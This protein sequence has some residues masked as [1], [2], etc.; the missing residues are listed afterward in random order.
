MFIDS[1]QFLNSSLSKLVENLIIPGEERKKFDILHQ[2]FDETS[3][4]LL[5]RKGVYP[6][7]YMDSWNRFSEVKL[8][9]K[10]SFY[11]TLREE[12]ISEE[13][14]KHAKV[15]FTHFKMG[16]L[17]EYHD[18][19]L[20]AD[21]LQLA[22]VF[23][24]FRTLSMTKYGLDPVYYMSAPGLSWDAALRMTG[25]ELEQIMDITI[26]E[27]LELGIRGGISMITHRRAEARNKYMKN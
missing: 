7:D 14:Y 12:A 20:L 27:F 4:E 9:P 8:P 19:Y 1:L 15:V 23:E 24:N 5:L 3:V 16:N 11:N 2:V 26:H 13:D 25:V 22:C 6:Y 18:L 21:S 10:T 17:G